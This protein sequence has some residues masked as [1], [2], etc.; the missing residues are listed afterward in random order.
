MKFFVLSSV[1]ALLAGLAGI[2]KDY[3]NES[4]TIANLIFAIF[5]SLCLV[6]ALAYNIHEFSQASKK[7]GYV[8]TWG[9]FNFPA[10]IDRKPSFFFGDRQLNKV[11][12][13]GDEW[14]TWV[15]NKKINL[16]GIVRDR[17]GNIV[18]EINGLDWKNWSGKDFNYD[19]T[20]LEVKDSKGNIVFQLVFNREE[21]RI[22]IYGI[23]YN[24]PSQFIFAG[25]DDNWVVIDDKTPS[26]DAKI[27]ALIKS[28]KPMFRYP[29]ESHLGERV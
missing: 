15:N 5:L 9:A 22:S 7:E 17:E 11:V 6:G 28:T 1:L 24:G 26:P 21:H 12:I 16:K 3:I 13:G 20:G 23:F 8:K 4:Q 25:K 27:K 18:F 10:L 2:W 14:E 29:R 19:D